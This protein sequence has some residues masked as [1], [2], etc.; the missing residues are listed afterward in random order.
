[1]PT[2]VP[3]VEVATALSS[4]PTRVPSALARSQRAR[5]WPKTFHRRKGAGPN[6]EGGN[7][8]HWLARQL[9]D[10]GDVPIRRCS[11]K[12]KP[13]AQGNA[14]LLP[15][16]VERNLRWGNCSIAV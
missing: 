12:K 8:P 10:G 11:H 13:Q 14:G 15:V 9:L 16:P 6:Q 5:R 1:M 7:L 4:R 2:T 3:Y